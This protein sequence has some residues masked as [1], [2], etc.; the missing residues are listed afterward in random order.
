MNIDKYTTKYKYNRPVLQASGKSGRYDS[1]A[2][3]CPFV[4]YHNDQYYMMHIGFDGKS[5]QT[6]MATSHDLINWEKQF[7]IFPRK[8]ND[9]CWDGTGIAALWIIKNDDL[10][11][12]PTL[13]KINGKYWMFYHCYPKAGYEHGPAQIGLAYTNDESL[14][15]WTRLDHPI[16]S[17]K[18]GNDWERCGLYKA[19]VIEKNGKYY[20][21]YNAKDSEKWIWHEQIGVAISSDLFHWKRYGTTPVLKVSPDKWDENFVADPDVLW[22]GT[23][24]IMYYYGY[25]GKHAQNGIAFSN[26]LLS[27]S[28]YPEPIITNGV[29]GNIDF[30][31]AHKPSV[32]YHNGIL[33]HFYCAV[34]EGR[35]EDSAINEDPTQEGGKTE[36]RCITVATSK[37]L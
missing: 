34:R 10:F 36:F 19:C 14:Q 1:Y 27:W 37:L 30:L 29:K 6:A 5:Y 25:N 13:K 9:E 17:W 3:D 15:N 16:L 18:D 2:V 33:Y 28:K 8:D 21:F 11:G 4:F 7:I 31:H 24:W 26:D 22:D 20:L 32:I 35:P 12:R 23:Q